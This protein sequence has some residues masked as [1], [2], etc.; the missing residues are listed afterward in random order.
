GRSRHN[1]LYWRN[2]NWWGIGPG[3][4][5]H[6]GGVRWSNARQLD[7][8]AAAVVDGRI[9]AVD[10]EALDPPTRRFEEQLL[11]IRLAEGLPMRLVDRPDALDA[12]V[13][14]GLVTAHADRVVLTVDGRLLADTVLM[15]LTA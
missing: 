3:A 8:W 9:P 10:R 6:I 14:E 12:L 13:G 5:S 15:R 7:E 4:H 11:R 2:H 1:L